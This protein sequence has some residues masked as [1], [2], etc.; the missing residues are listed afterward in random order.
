[1]TLTLLEGA[2]DA[3]HTYLAAAMAAKVISLNTRYSDTLPNIKTWYKGNTPISSP[4]FPSVA[5]VG[6]GWT[7]KR[8]MAAALHVENEISLIVFY[9]HNDLEVRFDRLCRYAIGLIELCAAGEATLG[10]TVH[11]RGRVAVTDVLEAQPYLQGITIPVIL[12][13]AENF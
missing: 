4:E 10:Y 8:Q 1:M 9:G 3:L 7:P 13:K 11:F 6:T 12:D 5:L 2:V